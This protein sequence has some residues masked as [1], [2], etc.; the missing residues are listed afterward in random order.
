MSTLLPWELHTRPR[1]HTSRTGAQPPGVGIIHQHRTQHDTL[2]GIVRDL[3][4]PHLLTMNNALPS[5]FDGLESAFAIWFLEMPF[6]PR[7]RG[8]G[9]GG[10]LG[11]TGSVMMGASPSTLHT[12]T[13]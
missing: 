10:I 5:V 1:A 4:K 6:G 2:P 3:L 8:T 13:T 12:S 11:V 7:P 9:P